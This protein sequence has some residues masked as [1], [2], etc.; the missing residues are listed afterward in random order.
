MVLKSLLHQLH[1]LLLGWQFE[2]DVF[3]GLFFLSPFPCV[4]IA[5]TLRA[6][7]LSSLH[8]QL[9]SGAS[10]FDVTPVPEE[11]TTELLG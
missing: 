5:A 10:S 8:L 4:L 7:S 3:G 9:D 1:L 6:L 2:P 11:G